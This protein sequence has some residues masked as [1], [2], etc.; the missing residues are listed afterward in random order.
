MPRGV[1][2]DTPRGPNSNAAARL[3]E[4]EAPQRDGEDLAQWIERVLTPAE[5]RVCLLLARN[6]GREDVARCQHIA[7]KTM[8]AHTSNAKRK[9]GIGV[10][11]NRS[12]LTAL[13][14]KAGL[15]GVQDLKLPQ[16][17]DPARREGLSA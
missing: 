12:N 2:P 5:M 8:G 10:W 7:M 9:L 15:I 16:Y 13:F 4:R 14:L 6:W 11:R 1:K 3:L 17:V